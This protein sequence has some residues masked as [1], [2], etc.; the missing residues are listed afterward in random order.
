M[1]PNCVVNDCR[2]TVAN[3]Q[4][5]NDR[6]RRIFVKNSGTHDASLR[7]PQPTSNIVV[8]IRHL[9]SQPMMSVMRFSVFTR[10]G[11]LRRSRWFEVA[12]AT[13]VNQRKGDPSG[14]LGG[15]SSL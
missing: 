6:S 9:R 1:K 13:P 11:S 3:E 5:D 10:V 12:R 7:G 2:E 14:I 15:F 4:Q 8:E